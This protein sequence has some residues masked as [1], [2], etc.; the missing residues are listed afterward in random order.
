MLRGDI[1]P[2]IA[3]EVGKEQRNP[4]GKRVITTLERAQCIIESIIY[5]VKR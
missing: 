5:N 4:S 1:L 2:A 3:T